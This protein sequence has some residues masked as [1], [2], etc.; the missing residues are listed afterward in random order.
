MPY[1]EGARSN[2]ITLSVAIDDDRLDDAVSSGLYLPIENV[3]RHSNSP[4]E[5]KE[6]L[7]ER[8]ERLVVPVTET[9]AQK[10]SESHR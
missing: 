6:E 9:W 4:D 8:L 1:R 3:A 10:T 7:R 5:M 2:A